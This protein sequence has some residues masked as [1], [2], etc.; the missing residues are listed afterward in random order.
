MAKAWRGG[1]QIRVEDGMAAMTFD[2]IAMQLHSSKKA[3]FMVYRSAMNKLRRR[4][5]ALSRLQQL[6]AELEAARDRHSV[7]MEAAND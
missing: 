1:Q 7:S 4:P 3:V 2:E 5:G 6:A